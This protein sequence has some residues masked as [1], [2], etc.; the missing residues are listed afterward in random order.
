M[1]TART[2]MPLNLVI[3]PL[4]TMGGLSVAATSCRVVCDCG[5]ER[6]HSSTLAWRIEEGRIEGVNVNGLGVAL[7]ASTIDPGTKWRAVIHIDERATPVQH[8]ALLKLVTGQ[9]GGPFA[10]P[11]TLIAEVSAIERT[12]IRLDLDGHSAHLTIGGSVAA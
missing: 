1:K 4:V 5:P 3:S 6:G 12:P 11:A 9:L 2:L 7:S 8:D 10:E